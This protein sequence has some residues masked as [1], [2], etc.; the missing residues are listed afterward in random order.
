MN[1]SVIIAIVIAVVVTG[2]IVSGQLDSFTDESGSDA[3]AATQEGAGVSTENAPAAK[4]HITSVRVRSFTAKPRQQEV[5][6]HGKTEA[7]R[8]VDLKAEISGTVEKVHVN[9][10]D[11]VKA[12]NPIVSFDVRDNQ[13]KLLEAEALIRQRTIEQKAAQ[14]LNKK[15]YSSDTTLA[16]ANAQLDSAKAQVM[17]MKI[18]LQ[19]LVIKAPFDGYIEERV[20]EIGDY[21][22]EGNPIA[23][24]IESDPLLVTGQISELQVN[25]IKV[26]GEGTATLVTGEKVSGKIKFISN[27]AD[28]ATRTFRVELEVP[29][30]GYKLRNGVTA[31]IV[32]KSNTV[33]AHLLSPAFLTLNDDGVLGLRAVG[34][35]DIVIFY[36]IRI[37]SDTVAGIWVDGLPETVTLIVV[38]QDFVRA[39][40]R[41]KADIY[42][43]EADK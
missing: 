31:E 43:A 29:N 15:G 20:A 17:A 38:G 27:R 9:D 3:N 16:S 28:P 25:N 36:P 10:G 34:N 14:S 7:F 35:D 1:R 39:G 40:D 6:V 32:F 26:G 5:I 22:K 18:H 24:I 11:R 2:W 13:A 8:V 12:G 37:L 23:T 42:T 19:D 4:K 41:V 21:I 30:K 33:M